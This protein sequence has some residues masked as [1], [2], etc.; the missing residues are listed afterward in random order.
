MNKKVLRP[1]QSKLDLKTENKSFI[2]HDKVQNCKIHFRH[3][4]HKKV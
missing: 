3:L 2:P 4:N 1:N